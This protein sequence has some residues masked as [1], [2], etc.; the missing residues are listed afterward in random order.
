MVHV[1]AA[2]LVHDGLGKRRR[3]VSYLFGERPSLILF[4]VSFANSQLAGALG[5][6]RLQGWLMLVS[7]ISAVFCGTLTFIKIFLI[8]R[9]V[10]GT[11]E[12]RATFGPFYFYATLVLTLFLILVVLAGIYLLPAGIFF[13]LPDWM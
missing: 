1:S 11:A 4:L 6:S 7:A 12:E 9:G 5:F 10:I 8:S 2:T 3:D 13:F